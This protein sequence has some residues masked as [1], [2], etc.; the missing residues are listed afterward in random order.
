M[1][2]YAYKLSKDAKFQLSGERSPL[3]PLREALAR[4]RY[5]VTIGGLLLSAAIEVYFGYEQL[6]AFGL[7]V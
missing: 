2:V 5:N 1:D 3:K 4:S 7:F 6:E